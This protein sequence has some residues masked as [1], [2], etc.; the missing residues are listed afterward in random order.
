MAFKRV[1]PHRNEKLVKEMKE[2]TK[3]FECD[4]CPN[5]N[6]GI[7]C[8]HLLQARARKFRNRIVNQINSLSSES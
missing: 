8:E 4:K 1:W 2:F 3:K 6:P 7:W 5:N